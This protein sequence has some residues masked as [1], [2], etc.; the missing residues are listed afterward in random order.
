MIRTITREVFNFKVQLKTFHNTKDCCVEITRKL[1]NNLNI[2]EKFYGYKNVIEI[3]NDNE[4]LKINSKILTYVDNNILIFSD[5]IDPYYCEYY[6]KEK[7]FGVLTKS[8]DFLEIKNVIHDN[9]YFRN[10]ENGKEIVFQEKCKMIPFFE[11]DYIY[12]QYKNLVSYVPRVR[13]F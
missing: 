10:L 2:S 3:S 5:G 6:S 13:L 11:K 12:F 8:E 7:K 4:V 9:K 1:G